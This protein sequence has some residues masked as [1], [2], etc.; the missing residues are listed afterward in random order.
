MK[1]FLFVLA[2]CVAGFVASGVPSQEPPLFNAPQ[3]KDADKF[4]RG[5]NVDPAKVAKRH[6][7]AFKRHSHRMKALP[8]TALD[9]FD[10]RTAFGCVLPVNDQGQCGDCY[11][12]SACDAMSMAFAK[13]GYFKADGKSRLTF[14]YG[15]DCKPNFGG[16]NGGDEGEVIAFGKANGFPLESDYGPYLARPGKC[17]D[18]S[19]MKLWKI[20]D[21]G[22][23]TPSQQQGVASTQD[24]QNA[25][26]RYGPLSVAFDASGC[27]GYQAGQIMR[28]RGNNV[29]HAV[30][31]IGWKTVAGK[32]VFLGLNQW[33]NWGDNG[34]FWIEEGSYS[35]GTEAMFVS[36]NALPPPPDPTPVPP[37]PNPPGGLDTITLNIG[38]VSTQ[39]ELFPI[40]TRAKIREL[41]DLIGPIAP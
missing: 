16:C 19:G 39:Y 38:G 22:Y 1:R 28:G 34:T 29:D 35:W 20:G 2:V 6:E 30:L 4:P 15:L 32:V 37:G 11:G 33:G 24:M 5:R 14:Q 12:V 21:Y 23:C 9:S 8:N 17:R 3:V 40:G 13:A 7:E 27:N 10:C 18:V 41:R 26:V 25:M 36:V 31:C